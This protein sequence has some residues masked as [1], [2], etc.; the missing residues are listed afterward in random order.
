MLEKYFDLSAVR[1]RTNK[2]ID[3]YPKAVERKRWE[4]LPEKEKKKLIKNGEKYIGYKW[5][6]LLMSDYMKL[7]TEDSRTPYMAPYHE[8]RSV[9]SQLVLAEC[10]E[11]KKRF[12]SDIIN[13]I[14]AICEET[15]WVA[16][17]HNLKDTG[18]S[19]GKKEILPY[20]GSKMVDLSSGNTGLILSWIYYII[21][22]EL[23]E[24]SPIVCNN[25]K[26]TIEEKV[27]KLYVENDKLWWLNYPSNWNAT[28]NSDMVKIATLIYSDEKKIKKV[29][30]KAIRSLNAYFSRYPKDGGCEEGIWYWH[31]DMAAEALDWL[32]YISYGKINAFKE[33]QLKNIAHFEVT[34]YAGNN[35]YVTFSDSHINLKGER[36][37]EAFRIG[38]LSEDENLK[39]IAAKRGVSEKSQTPFVDMELKRLFDT[40]IKNEIKKYEKKSPNLE[41]RVWYE[42]I[43]TLILR[44]KQEEKGLFFAIKGGNNDQIHN[45][46]DVG[47]FVIFNDTDPVIVDA[48][49]GEYTNT[50]FSP[51]R[52]TIW[53]MNSKYHNVPFIGGKEQKFGK[54]YRATGVVCNRES[55]SMELAAAYDEPSIISWNRTAEYDRSTNSI[56]FC[57]RYSF[58]EQKEIRLHFLLTEKPQITGNEI[59]LAGGV[60]LEFSDMDTQFEEITELDSVMKTHWNRLYRL[61]LI[62]T[63][64]NG[65]IIY[66]FTT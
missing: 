39:I 63:D 51:D 31:A 14:F 37:E 34:M 23:D 3:I 61:A 1:I 12:I 52:Y 43:E 38:E 65:E 10:A 13:G 40:E 42:S 21:K 22:E 6:H 46:L 9:L 27:I 28:L 30:E 66:K 41:K 11:H 5:Q 18:N 33:E 53:S 19:A 60:K 57:E 8:R 64:K 2:D 44:E 48:G 49:I 50:A 29:L 54:Q 17:A 56:V 20:K 58:T 15:S 36:C 62:K 32:N 25:L 4:E 26:R 24:L 47:N 35:N 45:H 59:M 16:P 55:I 7:Y